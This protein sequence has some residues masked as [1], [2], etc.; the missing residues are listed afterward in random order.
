MNAC[1]FDE[2]TIHADDRKTIVVLVSQSGETRDL[3][4]CLVLV[5]NNPRIMT[6]GVVNTI[7]SLIARETDCGVYLNAGREVGVA[8][9]KSFTSQV[10]V[11]III[12]LWFH[13]HKHPFKKEQ[14]TFYID[15]LLEFGEQTCDVL[16]KMKEFD[17]ANLS[18]DLVQKSMFVLGT[19]R[20]EY[21]IAIEGSLK[22]K[23]ISY[24]HCEGYPTT[25]LK[26]GPLALIE[27]NIPVINLIS[28]PD[29]Y[30]TISN[31]MAQVKSRG[32]NP[33][34]IGNHK[35]ATLP[36]ITK[37]EFG[38]LWNNMTLQLIAYYLAIYQGNN[39]DMPRNLAKVVTVG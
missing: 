33:I 5:K 2:E 21:A 25:S 35:S 32:G 38:F 22:I 19:K 10:I 3:H 18:R 13:Q 16:Q 37:N 39:P 29:E 8:S 6:M 14:R 17:F 24:I 34:L 4:R 9:T 30:E 12:S 36:I 15:N 27:N 31:S 1:E 11:L 28:N 26:H 20:K 7:D 23:E